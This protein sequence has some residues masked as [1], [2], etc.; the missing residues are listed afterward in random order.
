[1]SGDLHAEMQNFGL[2][3]HFPL[4][5]N[6]WTIRNTFCVPFPPWHNN[7][8]HLRRTTLALRA[9]VHHGNCRLIRASNAEMQLLGYVA[10]QWDRYIG[11][12]S[13]STER[14][15]SWYLILW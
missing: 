11:P 7:R 5:G 9:P 4:W 3:T 1:L 12:I 6:L 15:S 2:K 13:R 14:I 8:K 10:W